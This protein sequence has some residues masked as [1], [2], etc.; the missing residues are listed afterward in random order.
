MRKYDK[1]KTQGMYNAQALLFHRAGADGLQLGFATCHY[2]SAPWLDDLADAQKMLYADKHY[3]VD[4]ITIRPGTFA[5][6]DLGGRQTGEHT[7]SL[8]IADDVASAVAAGYTVT[9]QLVLNMRPLLSGERVDVSVNGN[10]PVTFSGDTEDAAARRGADAIDPS[11][12]EHA[13]FIFDEEWWRRGEHTVPMPADWW[14]L[15]D[16]SI[17]VVYSASTLA[18]DNPFSLTWIEMLLDYDR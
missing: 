14:L 13:T 4:P 3:M 1:P 8:R 7:Y 9:A 16:N 2:K 10:G 18:A 15:G 6:T 12:R 5:T 17:R 11:K